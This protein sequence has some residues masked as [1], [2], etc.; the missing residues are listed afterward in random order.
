MVC[1]SIETQ[2]GKAV[3]GPA[4]N[5]DGGE[6]KITIRIMRGK[7]RRRTGWSRDWLGSSLAPPLAQLRPTAERLCISGGGR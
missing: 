7:R 1:V 2:R 5:G 6:I 4:A 3:R